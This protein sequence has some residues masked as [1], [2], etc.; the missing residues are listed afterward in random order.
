MTANWILCPVRNNL[1][2][3]KKAVKTFRAQDIGNVHILIIDNGSTD[4]TAEWL[5]TQPDLFRVR[6][7]PPE[8]V[9]G[10]WNFGLRWVWGRG[11]EYCLVVNNDVELRSDTYRRLVGDG[12]EFVTAVG[13]RDAGKIKV[14]DDPE[15][16]TF[17]SMSDCATKRPHPD[18]SCYLIR[19]EIYEKVGP[20]DENFKIAYY[21]DNCYHLRMHQ[22]GITAYCIDLPF[23]HHGAQT[24]K[25]ADPAEIRKVQAQAQRNKEYFKKKHGVEAGSAEYYALFGHS[26]PEDRNE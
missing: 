9:A 12:G 16:D 17:L 11:A 25:N 15:C 4:G 13:T 5:A 14:V 19:R 20:F 23:L 18:F 8:S 24:I 21:E 6:F 10:S 2:L 1:H 3:T 7:D 26:A 22:A